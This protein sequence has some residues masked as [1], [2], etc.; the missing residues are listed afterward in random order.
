MTIDLYPDIIKQNE[1]GSSLVG[2][3]D[4]IDADCKTIHDATKG[5]G[6]NK[7]KVIDT[8]A[9]KDGE[10]RWKLSKRY[11]ELYDKGLAELMKAEFSGDFGRA[12][13]MLAMP[14]DEAECYMLKKATDG[15]GCNVH[16]VYSILCGRTNN[17]LNLIKKNFFK[18]YTKDLGKLI[19]GELRGDMERYVLNTLTQGN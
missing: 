14:L 4:S 15:V 9:S 19:A 7:Q 6:A 16:V 2:F 5:W 11:P 3:G 8:L 18:L 13:T 1:L 12:M 17:E 10:E